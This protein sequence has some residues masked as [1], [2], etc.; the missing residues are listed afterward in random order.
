MITRLTCTGGNG[1]SL[2]SSAVA[3]PQSTFNGNYLHDD[4]FEMAAAYTFHICQNHPFIDGNKRAGLAAA[5]VFLDFNGISIEDP[6]GLLYDSVMK[7]AS[8][9]MDKKAF[10]IVLKQLEKK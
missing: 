7:I 5:L 6:E 10:A 9:K 2:L 3:H 8:G 1:A 4:L